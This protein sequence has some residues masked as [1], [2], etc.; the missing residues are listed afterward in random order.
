M[1]KSTDLKHA[2][3]APHAIAVGSGCFGGVYTWMLSFAM[4]TL[5][6]TMGTVRTAAIARKVPHRVLQGIRIYNGL[7][8]LQDYKHVQRDQLLSGQ[9]IFMHGNP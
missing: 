8:G 5:A 1:A 4:T 9:Y 3:T 2:I 7:S 6:R